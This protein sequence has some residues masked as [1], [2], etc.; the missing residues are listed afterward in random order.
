METVDDVVGGHVGSRVLVKTPGL[1]V[2]VAVIFEVTQSLE[3]L[4]E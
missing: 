4:L 2:T 1:G 3:G